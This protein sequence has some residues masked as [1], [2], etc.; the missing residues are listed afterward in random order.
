MIVTDII[1]SEIKKIFDKGVLSAVYELWGSEFGG[2][3]FN[4]MSCEIPVFLFE[5]LILHIGESKYTFF[6]FDS[7]SKS[8]KKVQDG[9]I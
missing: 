3:Y 4:E 5:K 1:S 2:V 8:L 7:D 9:R 6:T